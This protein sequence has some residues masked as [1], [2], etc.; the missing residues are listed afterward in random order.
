MRKLSAALVLLLGGVAS[1]DEVACALADA[2]TRSVLEQALAKHQSPQLSAHCEDCEQGKLTY[3]AGYRKALREGKTMLVWVG[4]DFCPR[5]TKE[6]ADEFVHV[7]VKQW[8]ETGATDHVL[9]PAVVVAAPSGDGLVRVATVTQ[10]LEGDAV[11]GHASTARRI[12]RDW[13]QGRGLGL[14]SWSL[15]QG[16]PRPVPGREALMQSGYSG[17]M[18]RDYSGGGRLFRGRSGGGC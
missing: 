14:F 7:F 12:V 2:H 9:S 6:T 5:C 13:R 18:M 11:W 15:G 17:G 1:G 4:G 8:S 10:W 16:G 3:S